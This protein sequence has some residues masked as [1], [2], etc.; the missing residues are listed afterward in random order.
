MGAL[1]GLH[2]FLKAE[3]ADASSSSSGS[4]DRNGRLFSISLPDSEWCTFA[5]AGY[6]SR[7]AESSTV[8]NVR[9]AM[10][11]RSVPLILGGSICSQTEP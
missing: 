6:E 4:V 11:W 9:R 5:A 7:L 10:E 8:D 2:S 3:G 1:A